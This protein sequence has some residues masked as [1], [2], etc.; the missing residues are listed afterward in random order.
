M[1]KVQFTQHLFAVQGIRSCFSE[2]SSKLLSFSQSTVLIRR[3]QIEG[4]R[5]AAWQT[6]QAPI[7]G[8]ICLVLFVEVTSRTM[9]FLIGKA[10]PKLQ[11]DIRMEMFDHVQL[12]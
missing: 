5:L 12:D 6:L 3:G 1:D 9:G 4:D 2:V 8:G 10:I 7:I 11:A